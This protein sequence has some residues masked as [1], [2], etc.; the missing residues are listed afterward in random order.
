MKKIVLMCLLAALIAGSVF[1]QFNTKPNA[2]ATAPAAAP[3]AMTTIRG[4]L[5]LSNGRIAVVSG[6]VTY[7]VRGLGRFVGFI[8]GLKD[9]AQVTLEGYA[10]PP[11]VEGQKEQ[12]FRPVKLTLNGKTYEVG[13]TKI[14][15]MPQ[16][17]GD[18]GKDPKA[19]PRGGKQGKDRG[20]NRNGP[21]R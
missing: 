6:G 2:P 16:N 3:A 21:R 20:G 15:N 4:T 9:G 14:G 5:G 12:S 13:S 11:R 17:R 10:A 8:D 7:Y 1:A 19:A 18:R